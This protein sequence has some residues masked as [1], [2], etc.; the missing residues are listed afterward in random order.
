[1]KQI[2]L[3]GEFIECI[4]DKALYQFLKNL[5]KIDLHRHLTGAIRTKT[6]VE[7]ATAYNIILP[8]FDL[9][10][11]DDLVKIKTPVL[12]Q[13]AFLK[14]WRT[15]LNLVGKISKGEVFQRLIYEAVEDANKD[16]VI[17]LELRIS[18]YFNN[19]NFTLLNFL[20]ALDSGIKI[21]QVSF[22][23]VT[24][25]IILSLIRN[26]SGYRVK[27]NLTYYQN[28]IEYSLKYKEKWLA[29]F[30]LSGQEKG[31]PARLFKR[32]FSM[33]KEANFKCTIH[34]G[35]GVGPNSIK[36][37][38]YILKAD[39][40]G[41]GI[42]CIQDKNLLQDLILKRVPLEI[43]PRS[44]VLSGI[45]PSIKKHPVKDLFDYGI[46]ITI[47]TDDPEVCTSGLGASNLTLTDEYYRLVSELNFKID[48]IK[49]MICNSLDAAFISPCERDQISSH[50]QIASNR[51]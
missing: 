33:A 26:A 7:L 5:P 37:A 22:P 6:I 9:D 1:M 13:S 48:D 3:F 25:K 2:P 35:E 27:E 47:N 50:L 12:T 23:N 19:D 41:H 17:Y 40:I 15:V 45:V 46:K 11:L 32:F 42:S 39:R 24:V 38:L 30:D 34:A 8:T 14:P 18:P 29:G 43:C 20:D 4:C 10:E 16:N 51:V 28:L 21:S 36:E 49:Q 31:F 44:N